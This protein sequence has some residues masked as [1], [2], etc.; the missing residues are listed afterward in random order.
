MNRLGEIVEEER[1]KAAGRAR[2]AK[3]SLDLTDVKMQE[4]EQDALA[5]MALADFAA[6]AGISLEEESP[7]SASGGTTQASMGPVSEN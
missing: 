7:E 1:T 4:A 6:Q 3:D 2:V 5:E